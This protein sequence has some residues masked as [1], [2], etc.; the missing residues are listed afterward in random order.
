M[1][2]TLVMTPTF[3]WLMTF[4]ACLWWSIWCECCCGGLFIGVV[5]TNVDLLL[6]SQSRFLRHQDGLTHPRFKGCLRSVLTW[7][8]EK[9]N[10]CTWSCNAMLLWAH[11]RALFFI[12]SSHTMPT[13]FMLFI[14]PYV[15]PTYL[16]ACH[17]RS[18][19]RWAI[20]WQDKN[21]QKRNWKNQ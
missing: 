13:M 1:K 2:S 5:I 11:L 3:P 10:G 15:S 8:N 20:H 18:C 12:I 16:T 21:T 19:E 14:T 7:P 9:T 17:E 4:I 6:S